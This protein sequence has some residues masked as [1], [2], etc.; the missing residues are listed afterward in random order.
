[1]RQTSLNSIPNS[2]QINWQI[3]GKFLLSCIPVILHESLGYL[4]WYQNVEF[5]RIYYHT[6][7][8]PKWFM[9]IWMHFNVWVFWCSKTAIISF[10]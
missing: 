6:K 10:D 4:D 5:N 8:E 3:S 1:M 7:F 2:I 9:N